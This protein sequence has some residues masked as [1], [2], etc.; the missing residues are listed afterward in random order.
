MG[1]NDFRELLVANDVTALLLF[2]SSSLNP[3]P[4]LWRMNDIH[5]GLKKLFCS[6]N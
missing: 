6:N 4:Y 3:G 2:L 5:I 1:S